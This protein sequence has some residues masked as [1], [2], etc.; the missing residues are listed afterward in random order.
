MLIKSREHYHSLADK[1]IS[2]YNARHCMSNAI[3]LGVALKPEISIVEEPNEPDPVN[4]GVG[5]GREN[6]N[7]RRERNRY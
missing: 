1:G 4:T 2:Q 3:R 5:T 7:F 6:R